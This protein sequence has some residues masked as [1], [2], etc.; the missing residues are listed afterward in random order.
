MDALLRPV[1]LQKKK[2][3]SCIQYLEDEILFEKDGSQNNVLDSFL[4]WTKLPLVYIYAPGEG[5]FV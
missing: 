4:D 2:L 3:Y 5:L 1:D